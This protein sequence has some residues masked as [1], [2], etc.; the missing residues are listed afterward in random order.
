MCPALQEEKHCHS[1]IDQ[2][3]WSDG[4]RFRGNDGGGGTEGSGVV[5]LRVG[6]KCEKPRRP[7][8]L[9]GF[10]CG[11]DDLLALQQLQHLLRG[12]VGLGEHGLRGL[13][14]HLRAAQ[15]GGFRSEIRIHDP[16]ARRR[17]VF[18]H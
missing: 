14:K 17:R 11:L 10:L 18:R 2:L 3:R 5:A 13:L 1:P 16:R 8:G 12:G 4:F 6:P 15:C 7:S 9:R